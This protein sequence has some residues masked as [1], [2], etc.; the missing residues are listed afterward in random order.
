MTSNLA[1]HPFVLS[2]LALLLSY[3][4]CAH[5]ESGPA[6]AA[7]ATASATNAA[8]I[9]AP[10]SASIAAAPS[11]TPSVP[12]AA[13][14]PAAVAETNED[15]ASEGLVEHH[16]HHHRGGVMRFIA[17]SLN[18][19]GVSP[20]Q[21]APLEKVSADLKVHL[22]PVREADE[23]LQKT[24][25]DATAANS[26]D[27]AKVQAAVREVES[28][29]SAAHAASLAAL[30]KLHATLKPEQRTALVDKVLAHWEVWQQANGAVDGSGAK[31]PHL[32]ALAKELNLTRDQVGKIETHLGSTK[33]GAPLDA[34]KV[35]AHI[36]AF[37]AAFESDKF[38][39]KS[40]GM[41]KDAS[42]HMAGWGAERMARF[43]EAVASVLDPD[44]R[45][46][47]ANHLRE[48]VGHEDEPEEDEP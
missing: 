17:M 19:L 21:R 23:K 10:T 1:K 7:P 9:A 34:A 11:M 35:E 30:D 26:F 3:S 45:T 16:R 42:G 20:E 47:F 2:A 31:H 15:E 8:S 18:T 4:A 12:P 25:A 37:E 32:E 28:A 13:A 33:A 43:V 29:S 40:L 27:E 39:A 24:L 48:H 5:S 14:A 41:G 46:R 22:R 36:K 6:P 44:Q 38:D